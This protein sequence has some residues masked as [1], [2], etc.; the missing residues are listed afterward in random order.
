MCVSW[1]GPWVPHLW[2]FHEPWDQ[3][4]NTGGGVWEE[5]GLHWRRTFVC[6]QNRPKALDLGQKPFCAK[7]ALA[8]SISSLENL[9]WH[10]AAK[11]EVR[12][13][14][15]WLNLSRPPHLRS[16]KPVLF[17]FIYL[18]IWFLYLYFIF[19]ML[20]WFLPYNNVNQPRL[21]I[22]PFGLEPLSPSPSHPSRSSQSTRLVSQTFEYNLASHA[23]SSI[24][25]NM[26]GTRLEWIIVFLIVSECV[27]VSCIWLFATWWYVACQAPPSMGFSRQ[28]YWSGLPF[29]SPSKRMLCKWILWN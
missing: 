7:C 18:F 22:Y 23:A 26:Q 4:L 3:A 13:P 11:W 24:V 28:E 12:G 9:R 6:F 8:W 21:Y 19:P 15:S 20:C 17:S 16:V 27:S 29:P 10:P 5:I 2:V 25:K 14:G 1:R